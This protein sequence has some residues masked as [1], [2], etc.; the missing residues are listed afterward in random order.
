MEEAQ[1]APAIV[2]GTLLVNSVLASVLFD[3]GA[4]HSFISETFALAHD[5]AFEKMNPPL[6]VSTPGAHCHTSIW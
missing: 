5:I 4:S 6:V 1:D 2:M 3:S